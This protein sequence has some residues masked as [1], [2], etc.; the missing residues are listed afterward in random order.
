MSNI[1]TELYKA[2]HNCE[3][4]RETMADAYGRINFH[5]PSYRAGYRDGIGLMSDLAQDA[6]K[7]YICLSP[8]G[9]VG[10]MAAGGI[11]TIIGLIIVYYL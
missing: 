10:V 6:A 9:V 1:E 3:A 8:L 5:A 7:K 11:I 4:S 2:H